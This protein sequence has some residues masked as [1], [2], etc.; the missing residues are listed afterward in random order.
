MFRVLVPAVLAL[1]L[2]AA[3]PA[4]A[5]ELEAIF[6]ENQLEAIEQQATRRLREV[7]ND[8]TAL[9]WRAETLMKQGAFAAAR[10]DLARLPTASREATLARADYAWY[11]G[12][13]AAALALYVEARRA[14]PN[15]AHAAWG[16]ASAQLHLGRLDEARREAEALLP[17]A[18]GEGPAFKAWVLVLR[19]AALGLAAD[20]GN[21]FDKLAN[22]PAARTAF[23]EALRVAPD[24][25]NALSAMGRYHYFAP[26]FQG[27]DAGRAVALLEKAN[28]V[29]PFFYLNHAYLIRAR[30]KAGQTAK[31]RVEASYYLA[32][33]KGLA[34]AEK[35]LA[36]I[37][38]TRQAGSP[39]H[40]ES[41]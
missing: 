24:N 35:E 31:A 3:E 8:P 5:A 14:A 34:E 16:V 29:D 12:D 19:G 13:W 20:R 9:A 28:Q 38:L 4:G 40:P 22:G 23:E 11:T 32:K 41:P 1:A 18:E 25:A 33:F 6:F 10:E 2:L 26:W 27:G 39:P 30:L 7:P 36:A 21:L 15:D 37:G 17:R